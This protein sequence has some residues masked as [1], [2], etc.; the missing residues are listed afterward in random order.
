MSHLADLLAMMP[1]PTPSDKAQN[2]EPPEQRWV[3][4]TPRE[5]QDPHD[6]P[7]HWNRVPLLPPKGATARARDRDGFGSLYRVRLEG[8]WWLVKALPWGG[9]SVSSVEGLGEVVEALQDIPVLIRR[10]L[11][12]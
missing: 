1:S 7:S 12:K 11:R 6:L 8:Q 4:L 2:V 5:E 3:P 9:W 10:L